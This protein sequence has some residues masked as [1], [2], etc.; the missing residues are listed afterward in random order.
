MKYI[1]GTPVSFQM[2]NNYFV[3]NKS[4]NISTLPKTFRTVEHNIF[5]QG[6]D[7]N[8][9]N[10]IYA[11]ANKYPKHKL[12]E[13]CVL[14]LT[15]ILIKLDWISINCDEVMPVAVI[16]Q[17][18]K[19]LGTIPKLL[20]N[21]IINLNVKPCGTGK[22]FLEDQC[23]SFKYFGINKNLTYF[24]SQINEISSHIT[25]NLPLRGSK[26]LVGYFTIIQH[27]HLNPIQFIL[28]TPL[29]NQLESY[30]PYQTKTFDLF[31]WKKQVTAVNQ[32]EHEG[33]MLLSSK[34]KKTADLLTLH[35]CKDGSFISDTSRCDGILDCMD[36]SDENSCYCIE[37]P[38][39]SNPVCKMICDISDQCSCSEFYYQCSSS[40]MCI[41][42]SMTCDGFRDCLGGDDEFCALNNIETKSTF[43]QYS[44]EHKE[45]EGRFQSLNSS[46]EITSS[47][48]Q[49][50]NQHENTFL[51]CLPNLRASFSLSKLCI[52]E[53]LK[54][55]S[56]LK[57]C[58]N[59]AHLY[60]CTH[61]HCIGYFKC[62]MSYCIP[63]QY[64]CNGMWDCQQ[65][66]DEIMCNPFSCPGLFK[67]K[68]QTKCLHL[69]NI[70]DNYRD[71]NLGEDE[72][73]CNFSTF[74]CPVNCTCFLESM[75]CF[76]I[77]QLPYY[78][79]IL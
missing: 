55:K 79:Y 54:N 58:E 53:H 57:Y 41:P 65:G 33:Y 6:I 43:Y 28:L 27:F 75:S 49:R 42:Y 48:E 61:F 37:S 36:G 60:N 14:M 64:I 76:D 11:Q 24:Q 74:S 13:S 73:A 67:C 72:T 40:V 45:K 20:L 26:I 3:H 12:N 63:F 21:R 68:G 15:N 51:L 46:L 16:C 25:T 62:T 1:D 66:E 29:L 5:D 38:Y 71:C 69:S 19:Q 8:N 70:C 47:R 2:W 31:M 78:K 50:N 77:E 35:K 10:I 52:Y 22:L 9:K 56:V 7:S 59:G 39:S 30:I 18:V 23:I 34:A 32:T 44:L 4:Y 17:K